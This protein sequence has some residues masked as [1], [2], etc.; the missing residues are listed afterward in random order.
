MR[1]NTKNKISQHEDDHV[2]A[3]DNNNDN[4]SNAN[5]ML[6]YL[7][8]CCL[9]HFPAFFYETTPSFSSIILWYSLLAPSWNFSYAGAGCARMI[10]LALCWEIL[11]RSTWLLFA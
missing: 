1:K 11:L 8:W 9:L 3:D 10:A 7:W 2:A 5:R 6:F 4:S